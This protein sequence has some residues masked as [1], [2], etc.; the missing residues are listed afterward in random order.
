MKLIGKK[1][2]PLTPEEMVI[3]RK[4][5]TQNFDMM[6]VK[7]ALKLLRMVMFTDEDPE[8]LDGYYLA[9]L[10]RRLHMIINW[11]DYPERLI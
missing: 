6:S 8:M 10:I 7:D 3:F 11:T 1:F 2:D 4:R 9:L 5:Y